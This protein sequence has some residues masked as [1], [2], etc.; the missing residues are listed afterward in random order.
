[1]LARTELPEVF[2]N[3]QTAHSYGISDKTKVWIQGENGGINAL[4]RIDDAIMAN[5]AF[6]YQGYWHKS[7]AV[8]FLTCERLTD[9]GEQAAFYEAFCAVTPA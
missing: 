7:G 5:T 6:M 1:M 3:S 8:N 2:V 9:M 4:A